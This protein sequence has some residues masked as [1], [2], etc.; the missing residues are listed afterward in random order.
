MEP[1]QATS[2]QIPV[3]V[4]KSKKKSK[5]DDYKFEGCGRGVGKK[6]SNEKSKKNDASCRDAPLRPTEP[7]VIVTDYRHQTVITTA[8]QLLRPNS[9]YGQTAT[10]AKQLLRA[11]AKQLLRRTAQ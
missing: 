5:V 6:L 7:N 8:K 4:P 2:F 11:T 9:Y 10:A 1:L 3:G